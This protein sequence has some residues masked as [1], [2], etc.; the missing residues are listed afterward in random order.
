MNPVVRNP[1]RIETNS[2]PARSVRQADRRRVARNASRSTSEFI[3]FFPAGFQEVV[4]SVLEAEGA[5]V[6]DIDQSAVR[7]SKSLPLP[8]QAVPLFKNLFSV[9]ASVA[10]GGLSH[11]IS[12]LSSRIAANGLVRAPRGSTFRVMAHIDGQLTSIER[13]RRATLEALIERLTGAKLR[14]RGGGG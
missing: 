7:F 2:I 8:A 14:S 12:L 4:E 11:S 6:L 9:E 3:G 5:K 13:T 10:R 1:Y